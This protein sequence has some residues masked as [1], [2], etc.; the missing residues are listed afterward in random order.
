MADNKE[1][2]DIREVLRVPF[3]EDM[4]DLVPKE[5]PRPRRWHGPCLG[6]PPTSA[7]KKIAKKA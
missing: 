7:E 3:P 2:K 4:K 6:Y 5:L 1:F